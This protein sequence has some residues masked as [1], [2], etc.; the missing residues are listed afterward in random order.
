MAVTKIKEIS[1]QMYIELLYVIGGSKHTE[2]IDLVLSGNDMT[3]L[4]LLVLSLRAGR[5]S[6]EV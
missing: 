3:V 4:G 1:S 6:K 2:L 5:L